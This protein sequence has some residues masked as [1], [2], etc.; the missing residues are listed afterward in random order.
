MPSVLEPIQQAAALPV[1]NGQVCLITSRTGKRW[2]IPKG[3][4]EPGKSAGEIAL[5]EAWE[6]AGLVGVLQ[7]HPIGTYL[8][9]KFGNLH[10]V[11]VFLML[12]TETKDDYPEAGM[13]DILWMAPSQALARVDDRGLREILR[14]AIKERTELRA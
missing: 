2:V 4:L 1:S 11:V 7:G 6:E 5:Q 9:E 14:A 12:V 3:C 10:H 13:R 8:Y